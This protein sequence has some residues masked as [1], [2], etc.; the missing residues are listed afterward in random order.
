MKESVVHER[1]SEL[2]WNEIKW[3]HMNY[4]M[5]MKRPAKQS[6]NQWMN[7]SINALMIINEC[8]NQWSNKNERMNEPEN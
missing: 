6:V 2:Y 1:L 7:D 4:W 8:V 5:N 3:N